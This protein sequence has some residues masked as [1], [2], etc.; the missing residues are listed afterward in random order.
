MSVVAQ[1]KRV[2]LFFGAGAE[3]AYGLPT[4]GKFALDIFRQKPGPAKEALKAI[5]SAIPTNSAYARTWFP[6]GFDGKSLYTFGKSDFTSL[7]ESSLEQRREQIIKCFNEFDKTVGDVIKALSIDEAALKDDFEKVVGKSLG[8][9]LYG[10][11]VKLNDTLG[12]GSTFFDSKYLSAALHLHIEDQECDI[13]KQSLS[14]LIQLYVG[15]LGLNLTNRLNDELFTKFP[16][17]AAVFSNISGIFKIEFK[18]AG[19]EAFDLVIEGKSLDYSKLGDCAS[20]FG[21]L[22]RCVIEHI[23]TQN[24]DYQKLIDNH[25]RYLYNPRA[26][27]AK[28]TKISAFL[29]TVRNYILEQAKGVLA[30]IPGADGYYHDLKMLQSAGV[31]ISAI[32]TTNYNSIIQSVFGHTGMS[33]DVFHLNGSVTDFYDP[34]KNRVFTHDYAAD[35]TF[36]GRFSVPFILTQ[37]GVKPLTSVSMSDRYVTM[38]KEFEKSDVVC[39]AGFGF[40]GDDGHINGIFRDLLERSQFAGKLVILHY[41]RDPASAHANDI[42]DEYKQ[43]LRLDKADK[44][45]VIVV[46]GDRKTVADVLWVEK[47]LQMVGLTLTPA[48]T[49]P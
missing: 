12:A 48:G 18:Q 20:K 39:V 24:L 19:L 49:T 6:D 38:Y 44:L 43:K 34:Y 8:D 31:K 1:P 3:V 32:G 36:G 47:L 21:Y 16:T 25:F 27:W 14:S 9:I 30:S 46:G 7:L 37:T 23:L 45:Y 40:N 5:I 29:Y 42:K 28:F 17:N 41:E 22:M 33:A 15:A 13:L 26:E 10:G 2:G 4:G 35:K 11:E